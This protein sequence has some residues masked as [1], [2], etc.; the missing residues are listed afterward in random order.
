MADGCKD[1]RFLLPSFC[2]EFLKGGWGVGGGKVRLLGGR[3][4]WISDTYGAIQSPKH[5]HVFP[6]EIA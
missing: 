1:Y 6:F 2:A 3:K 5:R 4:K